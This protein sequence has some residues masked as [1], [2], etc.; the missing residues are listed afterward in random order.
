MITETCAFGTI[1]EIIYWETL[2]SCPFGNRA[3]NI[4]GAEL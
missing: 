4:G 2:I 3:N 1:L